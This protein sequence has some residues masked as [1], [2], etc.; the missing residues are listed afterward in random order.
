MQVKGARGE[1]GNKNLY[2][3]PD[4]AEQNVFYP[5]YLYCVS[6]LK[7]V[8]KVQISHEQMTHKLSDGEN[9]IL[10]NI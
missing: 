6:S 4:L 9:H 8:H 5:Y 10:M 7:V 2:I 3:R 1:D